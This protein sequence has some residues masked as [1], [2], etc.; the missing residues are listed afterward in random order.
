MA[1]KPSVSRWTSPCQDGLV[2]VKMDWNFSP[3]QDGLIFKMDCNIY[4]LTILHGES[5]YM[6]VTTGPPGVNRLEMAMSTIL[7]NE[8][9]FL[10][11]KKLDLFSLSSSSTQIKIDGRDRRNPL[12]D[13]CPQNSSMDH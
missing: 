6:V 13:L 3:C 12:I 1:K 10:D 5:K 2:R 8:Q 11:F 9:Q 4:I 7:V